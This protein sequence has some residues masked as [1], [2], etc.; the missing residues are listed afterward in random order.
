ME[1]CE[2][3]VEQRLWLQSLSWIVEVPCWQML[4]CICPIWS[5]ISDPCRSL[6][7]IPESHPSPIRSFESPMPICATIT[8]KGLLC[9]AVVWGRYCRLS[10]AHLLVAPGSHSFLTLWALCQ[11]TL[12]RGMGMGEGLVFSRHLPKKQIFFSLKIQQSNLAFATSYH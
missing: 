4:R 12:K 8:H 5:S 11:D 3:Y 2:A 9:H 10:Q 6:M 1:S 7:I